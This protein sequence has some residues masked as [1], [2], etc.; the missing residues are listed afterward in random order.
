MIDYRVKLIHLFDE[1]LNEAEKR[2]IGCFDLLSASKNGIVL[3]GAGNIGKQTL[4]TLRKNGI[5]PLCFADAK[6][7]KRL[8]RIEGLPVLSPAEAA[9]MYGS[10]ALFV[11]TILSRDFGNDYKSVFDSLA[12]LG[13]ASI[14]PFHVIAWKYSKD[15]LPHYAQGCPRDVLPHKD[16][17]L[18]AF[19]FFNDQRSQEVFCELAS[20]STNPDYYHFS[21]YDEG[22]QY[23]TPEILQ[24]LPER[25]LT[26]VDCGAY[27]GDTLRDFIK[28]AG[29]EHIKAWYAFEPDPDN[30]TKLMSYVA[31][32]AADLRQKVHCFQNA[33][34]AECFDVS[35]S[36]D[37]T[38]SATANCDNGISVPCLS[39]DSI[40]ADIR[41]DFIKMD[42]EGYEKEALT[43]AKHTLA[44]D[45]P[46]LALSVYH[47]PKDFFEIPNWIA[48]HTSNELHNAKRN[49]VLRRYM[50]YFYDS[51]LYSI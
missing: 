3:Y 46:V 33:V 23:F 2:S 49:F 18:T 38:E 27:D 16:A 39:L 5:S 41:T 36:A 44:R 35:F 40:F 31:N 17:V 13:V 26:V 48:D 47:K 10:T 8:T 6:A 11:V 12:K 15:L 42:I 21:K 19:D 30:F 1:G 14:I 7:Y 4:K 25:P 51:V 32:S 34:G 45:D 20:V 24:R 28:F 9:S 43:G 29:V 50:S 22:P 37:G